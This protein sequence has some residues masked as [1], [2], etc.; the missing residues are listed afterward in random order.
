[1]LLGESSVLEKPDM[2]TL[3]DKE[4][5]V[6]PIDKKEENKDKEMKIEQVLDEKE[7][8]QKENKDVSLNQNVKETFEFIQ[9]NGFAPKKKLS[10]NIYWS[11]L[12]KTNSLKYEKPTISDLN[13][14]YVTALILQKFHDDVYPSTRINIHSGWRSKGYNATIK[15]AATKSAHLEGKAIDFDL[16]PDISPDTLRIKIVGWGFKGRKRSYKTF[17][18][19]DIRTSNKGYSNDW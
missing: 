1:M 3:A 12:I 16:G 14:L 17:L 15:G 4:Y 5:E 6:K 8:I 19:I 10:N 9:K 2:I 13:N 18:H 11:E 7:I